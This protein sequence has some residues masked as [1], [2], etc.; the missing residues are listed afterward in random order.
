MSK[1]MT[2]YEAKNLLHDF[3]RKGIYLS[4]GRMDKAIEILG[5]KEAEK[6]ERSAI[7]ARNKA[8]WKKERK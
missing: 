3:Y 6:I 7:Q 8:K 4:P 2:Q 1:R 5:K